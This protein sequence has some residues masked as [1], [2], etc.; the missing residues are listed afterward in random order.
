MSDAPSIDIFLKYLISGR[1]ASTKSLELESVGVELLS[2]KVIGGFENDNEK[3]SV[4]NIY[5]IGD[6][7]HVIQSIL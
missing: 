6:V 1:R 3:S 2:G 4:P 7:L 5:A